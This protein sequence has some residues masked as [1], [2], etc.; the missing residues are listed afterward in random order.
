VNQK[1]QNF[2]N[3]KSIAVIGVS[4]SSKKMGNAIYKTLR[5]NGHKVYPVH[6]FEE[7]I[8]GD[9]AFKDVRSLPDGIDAAVIAISPDK[10]EGVMDDITQCGIKKIWFQ[11]GADFSAA[12]RKA[13]AAGMDVV[14]KKCILMYAPPVKGIHSF[15]RFLAKIFGRL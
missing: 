15:H 4:P 2:I 8:M 5:D 10:A 3:S 14:S 1:I 12:I 13:E 11:R 6:P 7:T 9:K